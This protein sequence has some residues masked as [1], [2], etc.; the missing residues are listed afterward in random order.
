[1]V[2]AQPDA[3]EEQQ[4]EV[5][6]GGGVSQEDP[7]GLHLLQEDQVPASRRTYNVYAWHVGKYSHR[8]RKSTGNSQSI[9]GVPA[10]V[11]N[12]SRSWSPLQLA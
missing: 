2:D 1:M 11:I 10:A 8:H 5:R 7:R 3:A 6:D 9:R 12:M 4:R